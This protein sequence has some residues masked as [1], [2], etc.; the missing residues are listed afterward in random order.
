[1]NG[2]NARVLREGGIGGSLPYKTG[3]TLMVRLADGAAPPPEWK[4]KTTLQGTFGE[5]GQILRI[6]LQE[7]QG[8]AFV[9]YDDKRDAE[10]A[11]RDLTGKK[12]AGR[13]VHIQMAHAPHQQLSVTG[14]SID[15]EERVA[16][17]ARDHRLDEAASARLVSVFVERARFG[18]DLAK[19]CEE[20]N[21]H[22]AASNKPSA[23]VS[24]KLADLRS[25]RPIGPC[26]FRGGAPKPGALGLRLD[27]DGAE[28]GLSGR[29]EELSK[30]CQADTASRGDGASL[31]GGASKESGRR[32][33]SRE[34]SKSKR[35]A[36]ASRR[37]SRRRKK[38]RSRSHGKKPG[39]RRKSSSS[40]PECNS[41][42][43]ERTSVKK[44]K[45]DSSRSRSK[46]RSKKAKRESKE[47]SR[48]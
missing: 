22:L 37:R 26:K 7:V 34:R 1:M 48:K 14:R 42:A 31:G 9:E 32:S 5:Y 24:M 25:G 41:K 13:E 40:S 19:D 36:S 33:R 30:G 23:L 47:K 11:L 45:A 16:T 39:K 44:R 15:I 35:K 46:S 10:D 4:R 20:L 43:K 12:I 28:N 2:P 3:T 21:A 29:E 6:D 18:C 38:K 8:A 17:M 27:R